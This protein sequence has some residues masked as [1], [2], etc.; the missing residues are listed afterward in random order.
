MDLTAR[1]TPLPAGA[2]QLAAEIIRFA[3]HLKIPEGELV[4]E[5]VTLQPF[6]QDFIR[7][8]FPDDRNVRNAI[9]S[10][11]R[12]NGKTA[13][14]AIVV[15]AALRGPLF[16]RNGQI[17]SAARSRDQASIVFNYARR[18]IE[19]SGIGRHFVI[20]P[21]RREIECPETGVIY[22]AVSADATTQHGKS[23]FLCIHDELGQVRGASDDL[24]G[25][26][27]TSMGAYEQALEIIISTQA[28]TDADLLSVLLDDALDS[29]DP[30][31]AAILYAAPEEA[32]PWHRETWLMANPALGTFRSE[33]D[34]AQ[35]ASE[36]ERLPSIEANF[37]N[38]ILNQ[39]IS[40]AQ[41]WLTASL[42]KSGQ[43]PIDRDLFTDGRPVYGG[44]DLSVREDLT[45]LVLVCA[46]DDGRVHVWPTAWT[47]QA[48]MSQRAVRDRAPFDVWAKD[49]FL[50]PTPG[51][52]VNLRDVAAFLV[53][54]GLEMNLAEINVDPYRMAEL[55]RMLED[56]EKDA[57]NAGQPFPFRVG[58][59]GEF[60]FLHKTPQGYGHMTAG[61]EGVEH[62]ALQNQ[63]IHGMS[64]VLTWCVAN[65]TLTQ[66]TFGNR[67]IDKRRRE[68]RIDA[69]VALAMAVK[70]LLWHRDEQGLAASESVI[71]A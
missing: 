33:R 26:M 61:V 28:A 2:G 54:C 62:L 23:P 15:I 58:L 66:D 46:D 6:Q 34:I 56:M 50:I 10:V 40:T 13:L 1:A 60:S 68:N 9:L 70:S 8:A 32:D 35:Q 36:A 57:A 12:K 41:P 31:K 49:G 37:R 19:V 51:A 4:G 71:F 21:T 44:L 27:K 42:W 5:P 17:I 25:T 3:E 52:V 24:Y 69:A 45:A 30:T 11:A 18:M 29:D 59:D 63:L 67:K 43:A 22:Q 20:R 47:P 65:S 38:L 48:T 64:P 55:T 14:I 7:R 39:R 16:R 53:E